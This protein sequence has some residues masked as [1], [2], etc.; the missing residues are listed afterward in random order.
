MHRGRDEYSRLRYV[1]QGPGHILW[2]HRT[3]TMHS[4]VAERWQENGHLQAVHVLRR[5]GRNDPRTCV[6]E[7]AGQ[8]RVNGRRASGRSPRKTPALLGEGLRNSS[9]PGGEAD[10]GHVIPPDLRWNR[11]VG[12]LA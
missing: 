3:V 7:T 4:H 9:T 11:K 10:H 5:H 8:P 12:R 6:A 2:K 1:G